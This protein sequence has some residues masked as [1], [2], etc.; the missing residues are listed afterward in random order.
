MLLCFLYHP[1]TTCKYMSGHCNTHTHAPHSLFLTTLSSI[2]MGQGQNFFTRISLPPSS[3]FLAFFL[4]TMLLSP[5]LTLTSACCLPSHHL[6]AFLLPS[7]FT[8][9]YYAIPYTYL[10]STPHHA[11]TIPVPSSLSPSILLELLHTPFICMY[12]PFTSSTFY[13]PHYTYGVRG[14]HTHRHFLVWG[15]WRWSGD[16]LHT[17]THT[18]P[19]YLSMEMF[20][21][22]S[23]S[24]MTF[25]Y[26]H[27]SSH[28]IYSCLCLP[29]S[30]YIWNFHTHV[31]THTHLL[32]VSLP[33]H[34]H[35]LTRGVRWM[36]FFS[37]YPTLPFSLYTY[38][39]N[40]HACNHT[41]LPTIYSPGAGCTHTAPPHTHF[42]PHH[43]THTCPTHLVLHTHTPHT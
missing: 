36:G 35:L 17:P 18:L 27:T 38:T 33:H 19:T 43:A 40:A 24:P 37:H 8:T 25:I 21:L 16:L 15:G 13:T 11:R 31:S 22:Y 30:P 14:A 29:L 1:A 5:A 34:T 4:C 28:T 2:W 9:Y 41:I 7:V 32:S 3:S 26:T 23:L 6:P 12:A 20:S 42:S 39:C 10:P